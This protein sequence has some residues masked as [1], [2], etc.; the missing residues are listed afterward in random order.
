[1]LEFIYYCQVGAPLEKVRAFFNSPLNLLKITPLSFFIDLYPKEEIREG[2]VIELKL[3]GFDFMSSLIRDVN[4]FGF[5]DIALKRPLFIKHW[6]HKHV[7][8]PKGNLTVIEDYL[9]VDALLP[10]FLTRSF[11]K[12]M[13]SY[14]CKRVKKLMT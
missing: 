11:L 6:E 3:L 7:F 13:F 14:R 10:N 4:P 9:V 5:T 8:V 1:M 12:A 2:L